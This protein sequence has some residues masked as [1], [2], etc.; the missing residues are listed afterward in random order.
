MTRQASGAE[1][2][3]AAYG[4][5]RHH[6]TDI[7]QVRLQPFQGT[8]M[9]LTAP[10]T[11]LSAAAVVGPALTPGWRTATIIPG[12]PVHGASRGSASAIS[13]SNHVQKLLLRNQPPFHLARQ[14]ERSD[15]GFQGRGHCPSLPAWPLH[16]YLGRFHP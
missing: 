4:L 9:S 7:E 16:Q 12:S 2:D 6:G 11:G 15:S 14:G 13:G 10:F 8:T 5:S 1:L 3:R